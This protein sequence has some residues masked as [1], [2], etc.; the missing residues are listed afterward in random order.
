MVPCDFRTAVVIC[1]ISPPT[2]GK[3]MLKASDAIV[4]DENFG[5]QT[6]EKK[7]NMPALQRTNM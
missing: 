7:E 1:K 3:E 6:Q 2:F 5:P 4:L